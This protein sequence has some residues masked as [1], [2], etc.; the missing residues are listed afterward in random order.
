M[1]S[2]SGTYCY[3]RLN[4]IMIVRRVMELQQPE[5]KENQIVLS[6]IPIMLDAGADV[7]WNYVSPSWSFPPL[8]S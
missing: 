2:P 8:R 6:S 1:L 5:K 4:V 3:T 7:K